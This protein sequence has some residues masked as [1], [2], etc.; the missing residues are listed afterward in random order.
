LRTVYN[1][2]N[3]LE[4]ANTH[5]LINWKKYQILKTQVN[6]LGFII[7]DGTGRLRMKNKRGKTFSYFNQSSAYTKL[8]RFN[9][10][11]PEV[12]SKVCIYCAS[13]NEFIK[14]L[15]NKIKFC[16]GNKKKHTF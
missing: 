13:V 11:F 9:W 10:L 6:Y 4:I 12:Y 1:L 16:F 7:K 5:R 8:S 2:A 14:K 15:K 3:V